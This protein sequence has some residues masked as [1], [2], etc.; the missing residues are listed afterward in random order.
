MLDFYLLIPC[1][2]NVEGLI[3]SLRSVAY[4]KDKCKVLIVDDGSDVPVTIELLPADIL[5]QLQVEIIRLNGNKGITEAL[6][7]GLR[8]IYAQKN[9]RF[10][11]RLDCGDTCTTDRFF[12]QVNFLSLHPGVTLV[13]SLCLF[14]NRV[15]NEHFIYKAAATHDAI[16][17]QMHFKCSFIHPTVMFRANEEL[18]KVGFYPADFPYAEDYA[19]FFSIVNQFETS[20]IQEVLVETEINASGI[21]ITKRKAQF[22]SKKRVIKTYGSHPLLRLSG[23]VQQHILSLLPYQFILFVK[24]RLY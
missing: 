18:D 24:K 23:I 7:T 15:T 20:I 19:F 12:K 11:A 14:V 4:P 21:S 13:G 22:Y 3:R 8:Y 6:N 10:I 1:Y 17:K 5:Q 2:N 9:S 16:K